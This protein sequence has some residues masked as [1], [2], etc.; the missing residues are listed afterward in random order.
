VGVSIR[1]TNQQEKALYISSD[2]TPYIHAMVGHLPAD[3]NEV[4]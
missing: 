3:D 4:H 2:V 1:K